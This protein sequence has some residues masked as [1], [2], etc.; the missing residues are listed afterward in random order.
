MRHI[1]RRVEY[2]PFGAHKGYL[3]DAYIA[4][5]KP[6]RQCSCRIETHRNLHCMPG[7]GQNKDLSLCHL[8]TASQST[9]A[10]QIK[11]RMV[12]EEGVKKTKNKRTNT[13]RPC[14]VVTQ[15]A[16][17]LWGHRMEPHPSKHYNQ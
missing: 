13:Q 10:R 15:R 12:K 17:C 8:C 2:L 14:E 16:F 11:R 6:S 9:R 3:T 4:S 5:Q 7:S 1:D